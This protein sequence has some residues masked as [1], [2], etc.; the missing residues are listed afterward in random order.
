MLI[1]RFQMLTN[2]IKSLFTEVKV[3]SVRR[4]IFHIIFQLTFTCS[5][6]RI[7]MLEKSVKCIQSLQQKYQNDV[8]EVALV[9]LLL[10]L[11]IF[12]TFF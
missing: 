6:L 1:S 7:E 11:S 4:S 9:F 3:K 8:T 10:T 2:D 5:K 12:H